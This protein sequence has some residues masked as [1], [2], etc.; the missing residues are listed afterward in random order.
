MFHEAIWILSLLRAPFIASAVSDNGDHASLLQLRVELEP[1]V[2]EAPGQ[3]TTGCDSRSGSSC[4]PGA[5]CNEYTPSTISVVN[6][7]SPSTWQECAAL[8]AGD[9]DCAKFSYRGTGVTWCRLCTSAGGPYALWPYRQAYDDWGIF[10][11]PDLDGL[12]DNEISTELADEGDDYKECKNWCY[13]KKH[14]DEPWEGKKCNWYACGTCPECDSPTPLATPSPTP[15]PTPN[16]QLTAGCDSRSG[17]PCHPGY[18]CNQYTSNT[19]RVVNAKTP[20]TWQECADLC[21]GDPE[22]AKFTYRGTGATACRLCTS[23][24]GP[25]ALWPNRE[26]YGDWGIFAPA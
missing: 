4:S 7:K 10:T 9:P 20:S 24:G 16:W 12:T 19:K 8:C 11:K 26:Q 25:Y 13:S 18:F 14:A 5:F 21:G 23:A 22:C 15:S 2:V 6:A 17:S 3:L 1:S